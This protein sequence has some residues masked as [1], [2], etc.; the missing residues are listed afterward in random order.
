MDT[1]NRAGG[2]VVWIGLPITRSEAQTQR[3]DTINAD[4]PEGGEGAAGMAIF[5]DT[6]TMFASE[7]GGFTEYLP[8]AH[9]RYGEG[10]RERRPPLRASRRGH[11]RA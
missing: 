3:F 5:V 6:Y 1:V 11:H 2:V 7:S 10:A 9:D 4:R 8:D